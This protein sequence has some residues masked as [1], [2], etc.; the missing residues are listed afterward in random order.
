MERF[1]RKPQ[2]QRTVFGMNTKKRGYEVKVRPQF[3]E[4]KFPG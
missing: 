2:K 1:Y 4:K 3:L